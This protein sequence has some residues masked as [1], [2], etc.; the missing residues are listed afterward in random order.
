MDF[1]EKQVSM[2]QKKNG[3]WY[4]HV[5]LL[6]LRAIL[7]IIGHELCRRVVFVCFDWTNLTYAI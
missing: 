6:V 1:K 2:V 5:Q 3:R 7:N 4:K